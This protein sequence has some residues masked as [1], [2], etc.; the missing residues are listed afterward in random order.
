MAAKNTNEESAK[1]VEPTEQARSV[2][3]DRPDLTPDLDGADAKK[4]K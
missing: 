2:G 1:P 4:L 3:D